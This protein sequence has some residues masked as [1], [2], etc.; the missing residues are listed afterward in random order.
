MVERNSVSRVFQSDKSDLH[1]GPEGLGD[2]FKV[3][4]GVSVFY[5]GLRS[6]ENGNNGTKDEEL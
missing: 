3:E 2:P 1:S 6:V 4:M 5:N